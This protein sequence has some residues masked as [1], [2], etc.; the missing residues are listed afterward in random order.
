LRTRRS[1]RQNVSGARTSAKPAPALLVAFYYSDA[2]RALLS[3]RRRTNFGTHSTFVV[4]I[5]G[6]AL[7]GLSRREYGRRGQENRPADP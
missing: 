3:K 7:W 6:C 1:E 5:T 4:L 2:G